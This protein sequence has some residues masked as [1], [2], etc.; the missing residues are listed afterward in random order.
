[1]PILELTNPEVVMSHSTPIAHNS[2]TPNSKQSRALISVVASSQDDFEWY[3]STDEII[4]CVKNDIDERFTERPSVL[5]CGA[6]D[7]RVLNALGAS[8]KYAIEKSRPLLDA[9]DRSIF[10][11]G[12][13]FKEQTLIDKQ[14]SVVFSNPP[15][16]EYV[17]WTTKIIREANAGTVY[18]VIPSRWAENEEI[19]AAIKARRAETEIL[20]SFDFNDAERKARARVNVLKVSLG[21]SQKRVHYYGDSPRVDPF[22]LWFDENFKISAVSSKLSNHRSVEASRTKMRES[23]NGELVKGRDLISVLDQ[24]YRKELN[25]L[26]VTYKALED[27]DPSLLA[28]MD[29]N[30]E[31][32]CEALKLKIGSLKNRYWQE[33]FDNLDKITSRLTEESRKKL[34]DTLTAQTH[35]DFTPENAYSIVVWTLK[36]SNYYYDDQLISTVESMVEKANISLYKS[37][38]RTF[39][40]EDW[41]YCRRPAELDRFKLEYRVVLEHTGG[42][43]TS[44]W[45]SQKGPNGLS[46][47]AASFLDD[48]VTIAGNLNFNVAGSFKAGDFIWATHVKNEFTFVDTKSGKE[49]VLFEAKAYQNG[50]LHIKFNQL[51]IVRL[52]VEF[53]RLKGWLKSAQQ[54]SEELDVP[55]DATIECFN[56][57]CKLGRTDLLM[58]TN[59]NT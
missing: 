55:E 37:N 42:L 22:K 8:K 57:N 58:L 17:Q 47:R 56:S 30:L 3:P 48:L 46:R 6:G 54:A 34:L 38:E 51:F 59:A 32:L 14:V 26:V 49:L 43:C 16:S 33:L 9:L 40:A 11:V 5:D 12:T 4:A 53:G 15:Y 44:E 41:R 52:N 13:E 20:G 10:V 21:G 23:M 19:A 25:D 24:L 7:G 27:L 50:N 31:S 2:Y 29:V 18:L 45:S 39:G 1:M 35:V 36:Q 28:E